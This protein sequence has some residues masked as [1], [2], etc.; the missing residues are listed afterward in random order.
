MGSS[1][2]SEVD[3]TSILRTGLSTGYW[4][5]LNWLRPPGSCPRA[6]GWSAATLCPGPKRP[7]SECPLS[8]HSWSMS[9]PYTETA[10]VSFKTQSR[11]RRSR[12]EKASQQTASSLDHLVSA[13]PKP[14]R[15]SEAEH[16]G[17][18]EVD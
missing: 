6:A 9:G 15:Y 10:K 16:L 17:G 8:R 2:L 1:V 4:R 3:D 7:H 14:A 12:A 13:R 18:L 11:P 5:P